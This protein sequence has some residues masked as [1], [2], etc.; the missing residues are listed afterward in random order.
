MIL[1]FIMLMIVVYFNYVNVLCFNG[2]SLW[3][4]ILE[5]F[6][7]FYYGKKFLIVI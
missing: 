4:L 7:I 5:L 1:L 6:V 2:Y 3:K